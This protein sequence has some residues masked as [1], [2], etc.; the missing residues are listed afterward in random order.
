MPVF[1]FFDI[2][3]DF[4]EDTD[5]EQAMATFLAMSNSQA[6]VDI[7]LYWLKHVV[8]RGHG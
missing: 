7:L 4:S 6:R 3:E 5:L 2:V 8:W 1:L